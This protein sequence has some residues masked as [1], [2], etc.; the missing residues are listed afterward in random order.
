MML[1]LDIE[2]SLSRK[3]F[4]ILKEVDPNAS[5]SQLKPDLIIVWKNISV[6]C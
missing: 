5:V 3:L 6:I 4:D 1:F 2:V